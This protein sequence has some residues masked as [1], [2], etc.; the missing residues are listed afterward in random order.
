MFVAK[1]TCYHTGMKPPWTEV[2]PRL[3]QRSRDWERRFLAYVTSIATHFGGPDETDFTERVMGRTEGVGASDYGD[4]AFLHD[5]R[6]LIADAREEALDMAVYC[7][8]EI[9]KRRMN[10]AT[11]HDL[12]DDIFHHL[13]QAA[14]HAAV[15]D[16]HAKEALKLAR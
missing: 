3:P 5:D 8:F 1:G 11:D 4:S 15:S 10:D 2:M 14:A 7:M 12:G 9:E 16:Y 13:A 6:N